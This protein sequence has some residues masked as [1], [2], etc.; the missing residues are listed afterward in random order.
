MRLTLRPARFALLAALL[1]GAAPAMAQDAAPAAPEAAAP[2][3]PKPAPDTVIATID[4]VNVTEADL[5]IALDNLDQQFARLPEDQRRAA[6]LSAVI[7]IKLMAKEAVAKGLDKDPDY[8]RRAAFLQERALHAEE[9]EKEVTQKVTDDEIKARY[10]AEIAK[11]P[12]VEEVHARHILVKTEDEAKAVIKEL[13]GGKKFEDV[14]NE[15]TTDPSGKGSGGDLGF[16]AAGQMVPEFEKA[17]FAL[18]PGEYTKEP[19]KSQFGYHVI[20]LEEKRQQP[21][22]AYDAVKEQVKGLVIRD[23]YLA[24]VKALRAAAKVEVPDAELKKALDDS[25]AAADKEIESEQA[26]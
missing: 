19:V 26:Q 5:D 13:E 10:E 18:K 21:P 6:A 22:P 9:I 14:A 2:A 16:F 15:K 25:D 24:K 3:K 17:A 20:K 7:E 4:G 12:K 11:R 23:K 8:V 1:A